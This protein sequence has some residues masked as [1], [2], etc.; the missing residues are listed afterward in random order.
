MLKRTII[1]PNKYDRS[2]AKDVPN[3]KGIRMRTYR[4]PVQRLRRRICAARATWTCGAK[5]GSTVITY[6]RDY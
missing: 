5:S 4:N 2:A 1:I 6:L 3:P